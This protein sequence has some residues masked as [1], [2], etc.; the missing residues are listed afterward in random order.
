MHGK[1]TL[2]SSGTTQFHWDLKAPDAQTMLSSQ[3]YEARAGAETGIASCRLNSSDEARYER[4]TTRDS[5]SYFVLKAV[6]GEII[7][8]SQM[9]PS[10]ATRDKAIASCQ[11]SGPLSKTTYSTTR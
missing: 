9:Y 7:G 1:Y 11:A 10:V 2:H 3:V 4:L 6:N 5:K 8:T